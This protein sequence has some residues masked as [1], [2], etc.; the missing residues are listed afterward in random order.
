MKRWQGDEILEYF[1]VDRGKSLEHL[2]RIPDIKQL[3][4]VFLIFNGTKV[5][6]GHRSHSKILLDPAYVD[7]K[8]VEKIVEEVGSV[9]ILVYCMVSSQHQD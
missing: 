6:D 8:L 3:K 5:V 4:D 2:Q 7:C 9:C 1:K